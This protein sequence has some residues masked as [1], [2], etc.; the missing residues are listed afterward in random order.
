[1]LVVLWI[2]YLVLVNSEKCSNLLFPLATSPKRKLFNLEVQQT[3][4]IHIS[5]SETADV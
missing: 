2:K 4:I 1:M 5:E 3:G